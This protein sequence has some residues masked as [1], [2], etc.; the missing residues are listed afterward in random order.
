MSA[1]LLA[2]AGAWLMGVF[3]AAGA[4]VLILESNHVEDKA[5]TAALALT[6]SL[7][8]ITSGVIA[9][10]RRPENR[11]GLLMAATGF[12]WLVGALVAAN[13]AWVFTAG[14]LLS[15]LAWGPF[16]HLIM[17]YPSGRLQTR[18]QRILV[19]ATYGLTLVEALALALLGGSDEVCGGECPES[20]IAVWTN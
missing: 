9:I 19:A 20:T 10:W 7:S 12:A 3:L 1:R 2:L 6:A 17:A 5:A 13:N 18:G 4:L 14:F 16:A 15:S 8:F 11:T